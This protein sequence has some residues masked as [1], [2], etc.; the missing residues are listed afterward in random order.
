[1]WSGNGRLELTGNET[2]DALQ[3]LQ[4][5]ADN[6]DNPDKKLAFIRSRLP[7][8][9]AG[10]LLGTR[11]FVGA[12]DIFM[13]EADKPSNQKVRFTD[14]L[15][16]MGG[17]CQITYMLDEDIPVDSLTL[18]FEAPEVFTVIQNG[19]NQLSST[20]EVQQFDT[21]RQETFRSALF[22]VPVLEIDACEAMSA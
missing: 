5:L 10:K 16:F 3:G 19:Q 18:V 17:L 4:R 22:Q 21:A 14:R 13:Q 9:Q 2:V 15:A 20:S 1:M 6:I 11:L 7:V 12:S 8:T